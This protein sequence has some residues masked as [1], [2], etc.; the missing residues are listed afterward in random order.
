MK[1]NDTIFH[2]SDKKL[3]ALGG[4]EESNLD[5]NQDV[6]PQE[7]ASGSNRNAA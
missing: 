4:P 6:H 2:K 5:A 3:W 7:P 1:S